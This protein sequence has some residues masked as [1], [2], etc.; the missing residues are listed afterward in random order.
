M[1]SKSEP[2]QSKNLDIFEQ[3]SLLLKCRAEARA[4]KEP[5]GRCSPSCFQPDF[6]QDQ[7][8][9]AASAGWLGQAGGEAAAGYG[10]TP[11]T[12]GLCPL[13]P[14]TPPHTP[15]QPHPLL[16]ALDQAH[17]SSEPRALMPAGGHQHQS[18]V[19]AGSGPSCI[20][21][22]RM[23]RLHAGGEGTKIS[24][25]GPAACPYAPR[26]TV[27]L[28][29]CQ[30]P[31]CPIMGFWWE[32]LGQGD[33]DTADVTKLASVGQHTAP[34]AAV[35]PPAQSAGK[36][37][38]AGREARRRAGAAASTGA[39]PALLCKTRPEGLPTLG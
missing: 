27:T 17:Q 32:A 23:L 8:A 38:S 16:P 15:E 25:L 36:D 21:P 6:L 10:H 4:L 37:S 33:G 30:G 24:A 28:R 3:K 29:H 35:S 26:G 22:R 14:P 20:C 2:V 11:N 39:S 5:P 1:A 12:R 18:C 34:A 9:S 13:A 19:Q 31:W 7:K